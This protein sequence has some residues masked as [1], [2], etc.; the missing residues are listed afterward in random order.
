MVHKGVSAFRIAASELSIFISAMQYKNAGKKLPS[1]PA[2]ITMP[3][4]FRGT[5][6]HPLNAKGNNTRPALKILTDATS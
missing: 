6:F 5:C 1:N 2:M 4:L 3:I